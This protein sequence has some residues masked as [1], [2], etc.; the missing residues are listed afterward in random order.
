MSSQ[1]RKQDTPHDRSG[2]ESLRALLDV[3]RLVGSE[4]DVH[5][6]LEA[7]AETISDTLGFRT[8]AIN[9]YRPAW[10]DFQIAIVHGNEEARNLLT[11]HADPLERWAAVLDERYARRGAYWIPSEQAWHEP[12]GPLSFTPDI[13]ASTDPEAWQPEDSLIVPLQGTGGELLGMV[14]VDEP[15][16]GKRPSDEDIDVLVAVSAHAAFV[17]QAALVADADDRHLTALEHLLQISAQLNETLDVDEILQAVCTGISDALGFRCVSIDLV[18]GDAFRARAA[19]GWSLDDPALSTATTVDDVLPLLDAQ[20]ETQG[21]YVL[22]SEEARRRFRRATSYVSAQNG[23]GP[24]AWQHHWLLVPLRSRAGELRGLIWVDEPDDQLIPSRD[25]LQALR[26]FANQAQAALESAAQFEEVRFLADHDPLTRLY[27]RRSYM[28]ELESELD[29]AHRYGQSFALVLCD[30]D[31]FKEINDTHGHQ[32]GD[33]A[34]Q[35]FATVLSEGLRASDRAFRIGGDEFAL[36]LVEASREEAEDAVARLTA[37]LAADP[38]E[39]A[40]LSA[41]FG[42]AIYPEDGQSAEE[43]IHAADER[44]YEAKRGRHDVW[45]RG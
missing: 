8:V 40:Q 28:S 13:G 39:V 32:A 5:A 14:S 29:R 30:L 27:N 7:V 9:L 41:S 26:V 43:L 33:R 34:L 18:E 10:D 11:G 24:H 35:R 16:D 45:W 20:F 4:G 44:L 17:L 22:P 31:G 36:L 3:T 1:M 19:V 23:R 12:V 6:V 2:V 15:L 25:N 38:V 21:C 37:A 42:S